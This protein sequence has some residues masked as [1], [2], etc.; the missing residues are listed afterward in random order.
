VYGHESSIRINSSIVTAISTSSVHEST[1]TICNTNSDDKEEAA[2]RF[3]NFHLPTALVLIFSS[4]EAVL[5]ELHSSIESESGSYTSLL[6]NFAEI[7]TQIRQIDSA[8]CFRKSFSFRLYN[9][10][11]SFIVACGPKR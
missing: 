5:T 7:K 4:R 11:N 9:T 3:R 8:V 6:S 10:L 2:K 1:T